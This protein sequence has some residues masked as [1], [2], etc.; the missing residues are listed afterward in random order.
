M[1]VC[2]CLED[3]VVQYDGSVRST[4]GEIVEFSYGGDGMDPAH[5]ETKTQPVDPYRQFSHIR[6]VFPDK[7][8]VALSSEELMPTL[9]SL[10][11]EKDFQCMKSNDQFNKLV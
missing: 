2:Q 6:A 7:G 3:L 1:I 4:I 5:M 9:R 8:G 11:D 10:L